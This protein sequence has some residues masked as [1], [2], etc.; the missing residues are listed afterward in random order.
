MKGLENEGLFTKTVNGVI[1]HIPYNDV[2]SKIP[3]NYF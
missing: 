1:N 2:I 3:M